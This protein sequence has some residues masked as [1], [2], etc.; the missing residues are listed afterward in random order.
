MCRFIIRRL[1]QFWNLASV[2]SEVVKFGPNWVFNSLALRMREASV[3]G[4]GCF[5]TIPFS[6]F[7]ECGL[8]PN[9]FM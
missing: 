7:R 2:G 6:P 9:S 5:G 8:R 3:V 4:S 1:W